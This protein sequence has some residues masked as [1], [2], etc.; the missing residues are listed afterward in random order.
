MLDLSEGE[1]NP[2]YVNFDQFE[3]FYLLGNSSGLWNI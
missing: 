2:Q 1:N 3:N